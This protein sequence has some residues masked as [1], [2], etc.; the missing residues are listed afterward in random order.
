MSLIELFAFIETDLGV[1][2]PGC[3]GQEI[4]VVSRQNNSGTYAYFREAVLG[5]PQAQLQQPKRDT[6]SHQGDTQAER[7]SLHR[8]RP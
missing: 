1:E 5:H 4:V 2:V 7:A 3:Q 8:F 6:Q